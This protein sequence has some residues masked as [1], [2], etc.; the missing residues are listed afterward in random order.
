MKDGEKMEKL[1]FTFKE[2]AEAACVSAPTLRMW[3]RQLNCPVIMVGKKYLFPIEAYKRWL[4]GQA[5]HA[6]HS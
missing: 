1:N 2:A 3:V 5:T 4:E 6:D